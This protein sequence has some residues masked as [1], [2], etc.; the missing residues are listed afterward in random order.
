S[1]NTQVKNKFEK[2]RGFNFMSRVLAGSTHLRKV[3][4][5]GVSPASRLSESPASCPAEPTRVAGRPPLRQTRR[6]TLRFPEIA[7]LFDRAKMHRAEY[8]SSTQHQGLFAVD[9][10]ALR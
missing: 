2:H 4:A 6:L 1:A 7:R 9:P 5:A 10:Y 3:V 8:L